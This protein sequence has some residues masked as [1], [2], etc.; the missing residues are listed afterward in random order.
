MTKQT[1]K[2]TF[3]VGRG[4][5]AALWENSGQN[6]TWYNVTITRTYKDKSGMLQ[7]ATTF[8]R[9]DLP[10]VEK[11]AAAAF[12]YLLDLARDEEPAGDTDVPA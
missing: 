7:T 2:Q 8:S 4:I 10:F 6:G 3:R 12:G 11:A 1:P 9:N 5:E